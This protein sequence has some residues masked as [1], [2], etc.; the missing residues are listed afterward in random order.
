MTFLHAWAFGFAGLAPV[1]ALLYFMKVRRRRATV[2]TLMFW[3]R[4]LVENPRRTAFRR[5]RQ[6]LSLLLHLLIFALILLALSR[7]ES[8]RFAGQGN[9]TVLILD[10]RARMQAIESD[11][12]S[13]FEKARLAAGD[14]AR[15]A[16]PQNAIAILSAAATTEVAVPFSD[17][18]K[19]LHDALAQLIPTDS[20]GDLD[21]AV[22]L[23]DELL[24]SR[25]GEKRIVVFTD[26]EPKIQSP[27]SEIEFVAVGEP[28]DNLAITRFSARPLLNSPQTSEVLLEL[29]N[30][31][32]KPARGSVE[33]YL[34][35]ALLDVK[36]F[37]L[38]PD[39]RLVTASPALP[40]AGHGQLRARLDVKDALAVDN[41]AFAT[42]PVPRKTHVLLVTRGNWFLEK[43]LGAD[44]LVA[45]ELL[46]PE[47]FKKEMAA[48]FDAVVLDDA[49]PPNFDLTS[50]PGNFLFVK[51]T[52]YN[53]DG[54]LDQPLVS[55]V[56]TQSPLLRLVTL[57]NVT[58]LRSNR[59]AIPALPGEWKFSAPLR[60]FENPLIITA[61]RGGQRVAAFS[62]DLA[63]TDLPLRVAFPLLMSNTLQWLAGHQESARASMH[64]GESIAL[65][66]GQTVRIKDAT[67]AGAFRPVKNGWYSLDTQN[68]SS[69]L[70]VNTFDQRESD[71][72]SA[73]MS[74][75]RPSVPA[76]AVRQL[77]RIPVWMGF[78]VAA[79]VL[80]TLEWWLFHRRRTE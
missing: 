1:I 6:L 8:A 73:P 54:I 26:A 43:M 20:G 14:Y 34:D 59:A 24:V 3:Q 49:L 74:S 40:R 2:S 7:P 50:A 80:F 42:I 22:K 72:R 44:E 10:L 70:A 29:R 35:D 12:T 27:K 38:K 77:T 58:F 45:F 25:P 71:L 61:E 75:H 46:G 68:S 5:L 19:P 21:A 78:A 63:E 28:H 36:P 16:G 11:G 15:Q 18:E 60:S 47:S 17:D 62:F 32:D 55:D 37:D 69:S 23:A 57:Q 39:G 67:I 48:S 76:A 51:Q 31:G 53:V 9:S 52:P 79:F 4:V 30:F 33:L 66:P 64:A 13:R 41:E 65:A 56:D